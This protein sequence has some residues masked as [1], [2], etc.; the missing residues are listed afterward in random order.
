MSAP[1]TACGHDQQQEIN[2]ALVAGIGLRKLAA[3][4]GM[5][6]MAL[7]RHKKHLSP[8]LVPITIPGDVTPP[9]AGDAL[10]E[11]RDLVREAK[12]VL[13]AAKANGNAQQ[14]IAAINAKTSVPV[15]LPGSLP[16][17]GK[18][19]KLY[20]TGGGTARAWDLELGPGEQH[21]ELLAADAVDQVEGVV[22]RQAG[23]E[24]LP[25]FAAVARARHRQRTVARQAQLVLDGGHEPGCER[26]ARMGRDR[27]AEIV[28][29]QLELRPTDS[30]VGRAAR[31]K[32]E[33]GLGV[34]A[35]R[36]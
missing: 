29:R 27:K 31:A 8:A 33:R 36:A 5:S 24:R 34:L 6:H 21:Q 10:A 11:V 19:P 16:F 12:A 2:A 26:V 4:Y 15:L 32:A 13:A 35:I 18:V 14:Q 25:G 30:R 7:A 28:H 20:A 22:L 23:M 1:C 17:A 3:R 9:A